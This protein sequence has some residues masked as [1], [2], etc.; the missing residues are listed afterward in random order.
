LIADRDAE[1]PTAVDWVKDG[2]HIVYLT[3]RGGGLALWYID[4][5]ASTLVPLT[6]PMMGLSLQPLGMDVFGDRIVLPRHFVD[7]DITTSDGTAII[8]TD[9]LEF[10]PSVSPDGKSI[11]YTVENEGRFEV[12]MASIDGTAATYMAL[13]RTPRFAPSG[14]EIVYTRTNLEGN[15]DIWKV[16]TR[17]GA[18]ERL[19]DAEE[20]DDSPDW[21]P[22]GR[23]IIF[24]SERG[25]E[26]ALWTIPASGGKRLKLD[27]AGYAPRYSADGEQLLYWYHGGLWTTALDGEEPV[28][29][30]DAPEP[31]SGVWSSRGPAFFIN[32]RIQIGD[33]VADDPFPAM[34]PVFDRLPDGDWL[35]ASMEVE[36]TELWAIDL[37]FVEQ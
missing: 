8:D 37:V 5:R 3:D 36:K 30:A 19:T 22:D 1:N 12:W 18:P 13:G 33:L 2:N 21:S 34:W 15:K 6:T 16:D 11:A 14:N 24:S 32:G 25:G 31:V 10:D 29:V 4:L 35:V 7:S 23:S 20:L 9:R 26:M 27:V 17:T 28:R